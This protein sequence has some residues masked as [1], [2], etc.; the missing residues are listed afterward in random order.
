MSYE[1]KVGD[2]GLTRGGKKYKVIAVED[3]L[4]SPVVVLIKGDGGPFISTR[5]RNGQHY[6][7]EFHSVDLIPPA[8]TVYLNVYKSGRT[9]S[10]ISH[11]TEDAA[12]ALKSGGIV[13]IAQPFTFTPGQEK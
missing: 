12:R 13:A 5:R 10:V 8:V 4:P 11:K 1:F 6:E 9:Y 7:R 3:A 2:E